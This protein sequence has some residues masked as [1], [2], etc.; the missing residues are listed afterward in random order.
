MKK[1]DLEQLKKE[2]PTGTKIVMDADID[3][4]QPIKK[5]EVGTIDFI[6]DEGQIHMRWNNG[7]T[8]AIVVGVDKFHKVGTCENN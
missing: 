3:D 5:G 7:R 6:D 8:L 1:E 2:Y 4:P